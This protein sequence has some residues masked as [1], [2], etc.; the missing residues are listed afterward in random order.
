MIDNSLIEK[1]IRD[2]IRELGRLW[3]HSPNNPRISAIL[4]DDWEQV[5]KEWLADESMPLIVRKKT[6]K[7]GRGKSIIHPTGRELIISDNTLPDWIY[8][9]ILQNKL[10]TLAELKQMLSHDDLPVAFTFENWEKAEAKYTKTFKE[11][12]DNWKVCHIEPVGFHSRKNLIEIG[13]EDI[14]NHFWK[15]ANPKNIFILPKAIGAL[16]EIEEFIEEQ[17]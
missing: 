7:D 13:I 8:S 15:L 5:I 4:L 9:N 10:Y 11:N 3:K 14:Q 1:E 2:K 17:R 16:G 6:K 12:L